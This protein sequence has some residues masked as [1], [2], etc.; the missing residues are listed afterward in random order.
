MLFKLAVR[1][2]Q[3]SVKDFSIYF[4]TLILGVTLFYLFNSMENSAGVLSLSGSKMEIIKTLSRLLG[5]VSVFVSIV[6][7]CLIVYASRFLMKRR[8]S[9]FGTYLLLGMSRM[10][11]TGVLLMETLLI[12][13]LSFIIGIIAGVFGAQFMTLVVCHIFEA[14]MENYRFAFSIKAVVKT[15]VFFGITYLIVIIFQAAAVAKSRLI[16]LLNVSKKTETIKIRNLW[17][18]MILF[19]I[20]IGILAL[21]YFIALYDNPDLR[22]IKRAG[23]G[24]LL[25][26]IGT[27]LFMYS[28]CGML[29]KLLQS[30]KGIYLKDLNM[31]IGRQLNAQINTMIISMSIIALMLFFSIGIFSAGLSMN[32]AMTTNLRQRIPVDFN[33]NMGNKDISENSDADTSM[34]TQTSIIEFLNDYGYQTEDQFQEYEEVLIH[35]TGEPNEENAIFFSHFSGGNQEVDVDYILSAMGVSDYNRLAEIYHLNPAK[36]SE[37]EYIIIGNVKKTTN[38]FN[39]GLAEGITITLHNRMLKPALSE[40]QYGFINMDTSNDE[41]GILIVPDSLA[42]ELPVMER[43]LSGNFKTTDEAGI[44]ASY[45]QIIEAFHAA[46]E[47]GYWNNGGGSYLILTRQDMYEASIGMGA[48]VIF[49]GIY[50]GIIFI[51][52]S[53]ALLALK[54]LSE[55]SDNRNRYA[56]LRKIGTDD[57]MINQSLFLQIGAFFGLPLAIA[58]IHSYFGLKFTERVLQNLGNEGMLNS[59]GITVL[60]IV[61]IYGGYFLITYLCSKSMISKEQS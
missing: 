42:A 41:A 11:V 26:C 7:G 8:S 47:D 25:G 40:C 37:E 45:R 6:L 12:G 20:S 15:L 60:V 14:D 32:S 49:I 54:Q 58:L 50:L 4:F 55:S 51:I 46:E 35:S 5:Y 10:S 21:A 22:L 30:R 18:S 39:R 44:S 23:W 2:I 61:L 53:A 3:K 16:H 43:V 13:F 56:I 17:I 48:I 57:R 1:N 36:L 24:I 59:A 31:F 29:L 28:F 52:T 38:I 27:F 19:L 9:E 34:I 33:I